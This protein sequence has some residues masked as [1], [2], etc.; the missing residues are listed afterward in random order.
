MSDPREPIVSRVLR[1]TVAVA[2]ALAI[3]GY[4]AIAV[5][6]LRYP[7]ELEWIEGGM[8]DEVARLVAGG[9]L[10]VAPSLDYVP[11]IYGPLW[12]HVA[13]LFSRVL[14]VGF[15]AGRLVSVLSS[16]G[17]LALIA[18]IVHEETRD[19]S[20]A[21]A[22]AGLFAATYPLATCI[23]NLARVDSLFLVLVLG[24]L[25]LVR[26]RTS[27]TA[28]AS[29][30]AL[31]ALAFLTEQ[32]A[33]IVFG[34]VALH[35]LLTDR[36]RGIVFAA[37]GAV[38]MGGSV[39]AYNAASDG[40][41][42][43]YVIVLPA[44]HELVKKM[45]IQFWIELFLM[46]G[47]AGIIGAAYLVIEPRREARSFYFFAAAGMFACGLAGR[48]HLGGW[49][50]V[51]CPTFAMMALLFGVG[52]PTLITRAAKLPEARARVVV[53]VVL[54][55]ALL[56]FGLRA[57]DPRKILGSK[58]TAAAWA[59]LLDTVQ[60]LEGDVYVSAHGW[61]GPRV[62][63]RAHAHQM[64][65]SDEL[66]GGGTSEVANEFRREVRRAL[67]QKH[68]AAIVLDN[69]WLPKEQFEQGYEKKMNVPMRES[70]APVIGWQTAQPQTIWVP[71]P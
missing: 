45:L 39:L 24:G 68:F 67:V 70:L 3:A 41:F 20:A 49:S 44:K 66:R 60:K 1:L 40:W 5:K 65:L 56:Q 38:I 64:A 6:H 34:P 52:I 59:A 8:I 50:N 35:L 71:K 57:Y 63:K 31:F 28:T 37:A 61:V 13:A 21:I 2:G 12:F 30:A 4:L 54:L 46:L 32:S 18:R 69:P 16:I 22:A 7:Y 17:A 25:Y 26:F 48:L 29:A 14:G 53:P 27:T 15:F 58:K 47:V 51:L 10:Y 19:R 55:A 33:P 23:Y 62:G 11:F 42:W 43:H 36:R 9:K